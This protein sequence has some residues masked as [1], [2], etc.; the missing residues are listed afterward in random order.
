MLTWLIIAF[1]AYLAYR[2]IVG[3]VIPI[4]RTTKR[5]KQQFNAMKQRHEEQ[6]NNA[7][8]QKPEDKKDQVGEYI[9]F[10]EIK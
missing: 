5:V 9:P 10:E 1:V 8:Q 7:T 3:F 4:Y 2:F 6:Y